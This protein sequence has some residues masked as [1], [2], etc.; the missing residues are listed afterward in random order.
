MST[1]ESHENFCNFLIMFFFRETKKQGQCEVR[2]VNDIMNTSGSEIASA[3]ALIL[4]FLTNSED[5]ATGRIIF[6]IKIF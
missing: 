2:L 5:D 6:R 4:A 3:R 1:F